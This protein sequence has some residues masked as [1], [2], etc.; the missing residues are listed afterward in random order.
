MLIIQWVV[1][2]YNIKNRNEKNINDYILFSVRIMCWLKK[3]NIDGKDVIVE[4]YGWF[5]SSAKNDSVNYKVG[6]IV[7]SVIFSETIVV[8]II[9]T[10]TELWTK[11]VS[12][13]CIKY[14]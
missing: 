11:K 7:L 2:Y 3:L 9:L 1:N 5:D 14:L 6:N 10:G 12:Y 4:P 8:P 13:K